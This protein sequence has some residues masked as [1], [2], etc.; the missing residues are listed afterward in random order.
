MLMNGDVAAIVPTVSVVLAK[1]TTDH[2]TITPPATI[3]ATPPMPLAITRH[4]M[5]T[6]IIATIA[7]PIALVPARMRAG[8]AALVNVDDLRRSCGRTKQ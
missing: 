3:T 2:D 8:A 1:A 6:A 5:L 7:A 4:T